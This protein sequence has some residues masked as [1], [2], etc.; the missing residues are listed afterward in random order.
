MVSEIGRYTWG[1]TIGLNLGEAW[2]FVTSEYGR[3]YTVAYAAP[4]DHEAIAAVYGPDA[5]SCAWPQDRFVQLIM[6]HIP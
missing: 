5:A 1:H 6:T 2:Q 4:I 3:I